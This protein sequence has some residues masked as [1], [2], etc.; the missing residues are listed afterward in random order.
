MSNNQI[1]V[2]G[3]S[4]YIGKS[5]CLRVRDEFGGLATSSTGGNGLLRLQLSVPNEFDYQIIHPFDVVLISAA[6]SSP[7]I[8]A[9][10][11][12][13]AWDVNVK[14]TSDFISKVIDRGGRVI[15]FSSDTIYGE[16]DDEFDENASCNPAGEYA[17][18][19]REVEKRYLGN[20]QFKSIR[21]SYVF[22]K[23]DKFTKY[24][25]GCVDRDEEAEIFHPFYR[26]VIHRDDVVDGA[27]ALA[28]DWDKFP[29][30]IINF[31][32]PEVL[33][34]TDFA[35]ILKEVSLSKLHFR[36][37][38]PEASFFKN[39]PRVIAMQSPILPKLLGRPVRALSEAA[40][41]EF[42]SV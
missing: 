38:E 28:N 18:M 39:R 5:L 4:G 13:R 42:M 34:R 8:C 12:D 23:E 16:R 7:D 22:S 17:E 37:V 32:G 2:V 14:G 31:G 41:F 30:G 35:E 3:G 9:R 25:V 11:H 29:Q 24:L 40:K 6:I 1:I 33:A 19:K 27:I 15:F 26:S 20:P 10:E 21:L 36:V